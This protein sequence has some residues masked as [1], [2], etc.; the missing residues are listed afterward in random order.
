MA[1]T[2]EF[3]AHLLDLLQPLSGVSARGMFGGWGIYHG[4]KMFALVAFDTFYVKVDDAS[5]SEFESLGLKAFEYERGEGKRASMDYYTVPADALD[6]APLLCEW[7]EKG[8]AA[9]RRAALGKKS[10]KPVTPRKR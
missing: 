1:K 5:R 2:S 9:A 3:V 4:G 10:R 8:I 7:S 6:S